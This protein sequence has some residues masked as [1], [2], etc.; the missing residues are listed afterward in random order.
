[1]L[2]KISLVDY[3]YLLKNLKGILHVFK[4][5]GSDEAKKLIGFVKKRFRYRVLGFTEGFRE[6]IPA[7]LSR[8]LPSGN[9]RALGFPSEDVYRIIEGIADYTGV[10]VRDVEAIALSS[11]YLTPLI[12]PEAGFS[13]DCID[14]F[15]IRIITTSR[16]IDESSLKLHLRIAGYSMIDSYLNTTRVAIL[17]MENAV[18]GGKNVAGEFV[19]ERTTIVEGDVK[20]Y[21]RIME[22][23]GK[24]IIV[25]ADI[26]TGIARRI[27][28]AGKTFETDLRG[29]WVKTIM[30]LTTMII[31]NL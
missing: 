23:S 14:P 22:D 11:A 17:F 12:V 7:D 16:K 13:R 30:G 1:M 29:K 20:R 21:W 9:L 26:P 6:R 31:V 18:T 27:V 25:Y 8:G 19:N 24:P 4:P 3:L 10:S 5:I 2:K 15:I 28:E